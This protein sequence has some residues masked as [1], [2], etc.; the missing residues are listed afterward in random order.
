MNWLRKPKEKAK[1]LSPE[2]LRA[3]IAD[4]Q[5]AIEEEYLRRRDSEFTEVVNC[6]LK[7][8][9]NRKFEITATGIYMFFESLDW[10]VP[11]FH[12]DLNSK[13][14]AEEIVAHGYKSCTIT[15]GKHGRYANLKVNITP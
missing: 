3:M 4:R 6:I 14:V 7:R 9:Q 5:Q 10:N 1:N 15:L 12:D 2:D 11:E 8:I 13:A